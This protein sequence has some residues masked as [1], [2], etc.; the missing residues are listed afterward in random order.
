LRAS[1][2]FSVGVDAAQR[3]QTAFKHTDL[4]AC[5]TQLRLQLSVV[6]RRVLLNPPHGG[7][8]LLEQVLA[9]RS[10][11]MPISVRF[12]PRFGARR[13]AAILSS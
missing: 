8:A 2:F 10:R 4:L 12:L 1:R 7:I 6:L 11:L 9:G 5:F 13:R 3:R